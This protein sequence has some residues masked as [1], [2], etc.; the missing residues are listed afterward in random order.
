MLIRALDLADS[1]EYELQVAGPAALI[2]AKLVKIAERLAQGERRVRDK[3]AVDI[4]RLLVAIE[5]DELVAGFR[6]HGSDPAAAAVSAQALAMLRQQNRRGAA[7]D[8]SRLIARGT[9][10]DATALSQ[11]DALCGDL[12]AA[13]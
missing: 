9:G 4:L 13:I 12:L 2:I 8:L 5:T 6:L 1:R 3:D 11:W 10:G 7:S